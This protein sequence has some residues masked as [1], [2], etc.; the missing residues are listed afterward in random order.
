MPAYYRLRWIFWGAWLVALAAG[1]LDA[2]WWMAVVI[3]SVWLA[4][5]VW[6]SASI[7]ASFFVP[8]VCEGKTDRRVVALTFDDGPDPQGTPVVLDIL[9]RERVP[10]AFFCI[11]RKIRPGDV[12]LQRMQSEGHL[13]GNHSFSHGFGF[14]WQTSGR[15]LRD[16]ERMD[17][18][19][20]ET[21][22]RRPRYFRPPYGVT[23]PNLAKAIRQGGY[24][25]VGWSLRSLD[26]VS[27]DPDRL[28][29][30]LLSGLKPGAILLLH[31]TVP[32]TGE[33]LTSFIRQA[34]QAGYDFVRL[35]TLVQAEAYA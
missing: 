31:D 34:R 9:A 27:R 1:F 19:C 12:L 28:L 11:G 25:S 16:L 2:G 15:M 3:L 22:G 29:R 23:N 21:V 24:V 32:Q 20:L 35:D 7:Q 10:A 4:L 8:S 17:K 30:K 14:D 18:A 33:I 26:T 13:V 5:L 6:G